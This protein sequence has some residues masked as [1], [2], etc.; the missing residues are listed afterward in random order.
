LISAEHRL[1]R[2]GEAVL[3]WQ[4]GLSRLRTHVLLR[5]LPTREIAFEVLDIDMD[6]RSRLRRMVM[7]HAPAGLGIAAGATGSTST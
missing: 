1:P 4:V 5:H 6:G 7:D 3:E 2:G